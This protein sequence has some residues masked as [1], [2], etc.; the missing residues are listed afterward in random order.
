[1]VK[2]KPGQKRKGSALV[3]AQETKRARKSE[4]EVAVDEIEALGL[5]NHC[6]VVQLS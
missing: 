3:A 1:V 5:G 2:G 4:M 6:S